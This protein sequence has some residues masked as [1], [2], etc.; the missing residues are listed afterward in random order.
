MV[1][2]SVRWVADTTGRARVTPAV[3]TD[4][5]RKS[6]VHGGQTAGVASQSQEPLRSAL[7]RLP[8]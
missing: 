4:S 2:L 7:V 8:S 1:G 5:V 3:R 6:P